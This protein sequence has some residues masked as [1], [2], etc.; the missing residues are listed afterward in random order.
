MWH[1]LTLKEL[2]DGIAEDRDFFV[3]SPRGRGDLE[4]VLHD[5]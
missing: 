5:L 3:L 1:A 2:P 4:Y